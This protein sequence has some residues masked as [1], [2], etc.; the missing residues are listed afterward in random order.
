MNKEED[1]ISYAT[2][3]RNI[4]KEKIVFVGEQYVGK[5]SII[6]R[7]I[8]DSFDASHNVSPFLFRVPSASISFPKMSQWTE[9][10]C[11]CNFGI[12]LAR[13]GFEA[14]FPAICE[15]AKQLL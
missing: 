8:K 15:I 14:W 9:D 7:F 2:H 13:N 1:E 5:T 11:D 12:Q 6:T 4:K 10:P 3:K